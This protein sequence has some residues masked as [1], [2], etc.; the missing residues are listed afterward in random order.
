MYYFI[1]ELQSRPDGLVNS[2]ITARSSLATGLALWYNRASFAVTTTDFTNVSLTL[3]D[4]Y[5]SIVKN[6]LFETQYSAE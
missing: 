6:E 5:G 4:Q 1:I 3:M 2:T